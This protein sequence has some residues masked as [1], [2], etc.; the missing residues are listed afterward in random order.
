MT[1]VRPEKHGVLA[2][3]MLVRG[4]AEVPV[5]V[6]PKKDQKDLVRVPTL[7]DAAHAAGLTTAEVNWPCTRGASSLDDSFPD[8]PEQVTHMTPRLRDGA[9]SARHPG[10]CHGQVV[11][12]QQ[13]ARPRSDL[14]RD[15][16]PHHPRAQAESAGAAP[17]ECRFDAS[18][19]RGAV[20]ARLHRQCL[21]RHV[22]GASAVAAIDEAGIREKTTIFVVA[23]HGFTLTPKAVRPNVLLRQQGLLTV[24]RRKN[25]DGAES[26]LFPKA[27]SAW[28]IAPIRAQQPRIASA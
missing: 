12:G 22:P 5:F 2:N 19:R 7:F 25:R 10:R 14:D 15:G 24:A 11:R 3:G 16:L 27:A 1:G 17:A 9:D 8:V 13:P 21:C 6:D 26:T 28:S 4:A 18:R 23:D 20:A